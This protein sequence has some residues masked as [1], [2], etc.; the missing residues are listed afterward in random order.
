[1]STTEQSH[2]ASDS[3]APRPPPRDETAADPKKTLQWISD[4][5]TE[6]YSI[7]TPA[8]ASFDRTVYSGM[9]SVVWNYCNT[10]ADPRRSHEPT[11][12]SGKDLYAKLEEAIQVHCQESLTRITTADA[13]L[14]TYAERWTNFLHLSGLVTHLLE[15]LE[16]R[17]IRREIAEISEDSKRKSELVYHIPELHL[18]IWRDE[19]LMRSINIVDSVVAM[20]QNPGKQSEDNVNEFS[21][22]LNRVGLTLAQG[23][24]VALQQ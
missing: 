6:I 1:M 17:W 23:R 22:S 11:I 9:Q 8:V 20:Q 10:T 14:A 5:L 3:K 18:T 4:R 15:P 16:N 2:A 24:L 21:D 7:S 12:V 19:V 13:V